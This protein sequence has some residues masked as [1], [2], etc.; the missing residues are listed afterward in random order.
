MREIQIGRLIDLVSDW[1]DVDLRRPCPGREKLGDGS[2]GTL[3]A[4]TT[5][6][7]LRIAAFAA[8]DDDSAPH[9]PARGIARHLPRFGHLAGGWR[10]H[11]P[12]DHGHDDLPPAGGADA[13]EL[14]RRLLTARTDLGRIA[15]L[16][17][18]QLDSVP[19]AGAF[20]FCDGKR[21]L[22]LHGS[23][24][25]GGIKQTIKTKKGQKYKVT[26]SLSVNPDSL[27]KRKKL[28]VQAGERKETFVAEGTGKT[29]D[30][31]GWEAKEWTFTA[32]AEETAARLCAASS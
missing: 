18:R 2:V 4:H 30:D 29:I 19:S 27:V 14:R 24:G 12:R 25:Y 26:F 11:R 31:M 20:R 22:D 32:D 1:D 16:D 23:P 10:R 7:Y 21:S 17:D 28:A 15:E 6:N 8:A 3:V 13:D 5:D 9:R